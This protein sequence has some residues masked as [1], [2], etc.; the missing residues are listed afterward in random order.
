MS[1]EE[2]IA[3]VKQNAREEA[4]RPLIEAAI[5]LPVGNETRK[6]LLTVVEQIRLSGR[7]S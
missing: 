1:Q 7:P 6:F 2:L 5:A 3:R 4:M